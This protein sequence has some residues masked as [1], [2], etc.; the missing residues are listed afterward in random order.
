MENNSRCFKCDKI[1]A[2]AKRLGTRKY[3]PF[4]GAYLGGTREP[5]QIGLPPTWWR[6]TKGTRRTRVIE[7]IKKENKIK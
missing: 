2:E 7:R 5:P 3:C 4:C 1:F 6:D